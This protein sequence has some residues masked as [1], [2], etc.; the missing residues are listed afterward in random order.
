[1]GDCEEQESVTFNTNGLGEFKK[2]Q[3]IC[4]KHC[5]IEAENVA[6]SHWGFECIVTGPDCGSK[7]VTV[8][9]KNNFEYIIHNIL[10]NDKGHYVSIDTEMLKKSLTLANV[11]TP[12]SVDHPGFVVVVVVVFRF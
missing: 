6:R 9:F 1:M 12:S 8:L 2:N 5:K 4:K 11:Y 7:G 10:K 3:K